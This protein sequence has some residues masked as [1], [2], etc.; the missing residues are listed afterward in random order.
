MLSKFGMFGLTEL[1]MLC[2][3]QGFEGMGRSVT[4][5]R[6]PGSTFLLGSLLISN[7]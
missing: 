6:F 7:N 4:S 1:G 5:T 2:K 3:V